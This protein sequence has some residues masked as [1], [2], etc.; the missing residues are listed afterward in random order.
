MSK[1]TESKIVDFDSGAHL[2]GWDQLTSLQKTL[3]ERIADSIVGMGSKEAIE[4]LFNVAADIVVNAGFD[5]LHTARILLSFVK[6]K[7][8]NAPCGCVECQ[9]TER[10][11]LS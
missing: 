1:D 10:S 9:K 11:H 3:Y 8:A 5:A 4:I 6:Q 2:E 7:A